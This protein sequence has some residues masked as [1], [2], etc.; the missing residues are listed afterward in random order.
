MRKGVPIYKIQALRGN[1]PADGFMTVEG[2]RYKQRQ[3]TLNRMTDDIGENTLV[4]NPGVDGC[5]A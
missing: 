3:K 5:V 4:Q 1:D 2:N